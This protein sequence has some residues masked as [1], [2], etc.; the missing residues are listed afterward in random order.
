MKQLKWF[1]VGVYAGMGL[2]AFALA[3][4]NEETFSHFQRTLAAKRKEN[5]K[6]DVRHEIDELFRLLNDRKPSMS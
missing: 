3:R 1:A 6:R 4:C 2:L 5:G